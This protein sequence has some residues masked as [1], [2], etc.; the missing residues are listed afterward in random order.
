MAA[1]KFFI[2]NSVLPLFLISSAGS[3]IS[4]LW[5][6]FLGGA[7]CFGGFS[8]LFC[9]YSSFLGDGYSVF[10][11]GG[12]AF[13]DIFFMNSSKPVFG[14]LLTT[15]IAFLIWGSLANK[16]AAPGFCKTVWNFCMKAGS[17]IKSFVSG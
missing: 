15:S 6:S 1:G 4:I 2:L 16:E 7:S 11:G 14:A 12:G 9:G 17:W 10:G 3:S 8:S 13:L 5:S